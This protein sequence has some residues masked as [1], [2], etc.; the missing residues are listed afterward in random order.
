MLTRDDRPLILLRL[1]DT[2]VQQKVLDLLP[3][4]QA[5]G[6]RRSLSSKAANDSVDW[7]LE[8]AVIDDFQLMLG[9]LKA[10]SSV[11]SDPADAESP[12]V[13]G[14]AAGPH[15]VAASHGGAAA[16]ASGKP[17]LH[18]HNPNSNPDD[19]AA[20]FVQTD[21]PV[22]DLDKMPI[23]QL[24]L[25]LQGEQPRTV[26]ILMSQMSAT[27]TAEL[28]ATF[29]G[30]H[31]QGVMKELGR[32]LNAHPMLFDRLA[33]AT[34]QRGM[35]AAEKPPVVQNDRVAKLTEILRTLEKSERGPM[36]ETI[37]AEDPDLAAKLTES[38]Y[39]FQDI[40]QAEDRVVQKILGQVESTTLAT[41]LFKA[42]DAILQKV[43]KNLSRRAQ[44]SLQEELQMQTHVSPAR[45][46]QARTAVAQIIAKIAKEEDS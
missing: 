35:A 7:S 44:Q 42:E 33:R 46:Q 12:V 38:L 4:D 15:R 20:P 18:L 10:Y 17:D 19:P 9:F 41:A 13:A 26:A 2:D 5:N 23:A 14:A 24:G 28:L 3:P 32:E 37:E 21:N 45:V 30:E 43:L 22:D 34:I 39:Q 29:R 31:K 40:G 1:L 25:A 8:S 16:A 11:S 27:R 36:L 6:L